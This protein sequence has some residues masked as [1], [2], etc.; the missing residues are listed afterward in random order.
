MEIFIDFGLFE[1]L[2]G[3][4]LAALSRV[5]Y[6]KKILG[7]LFLLLSILAPAT[8]LAI[9]SAPAHRWLAVLC[10]AT[11][12]VNAAVVAA[13]MQNGEVPSLQILRRRIRHD[14]TT[15]CPQKISAEESMK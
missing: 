13:V 3:L 8:L 1:L 15:K 7:A 10:L 11:A 5:V 6:S 14:R 4:G 12:L 9:S 2:A